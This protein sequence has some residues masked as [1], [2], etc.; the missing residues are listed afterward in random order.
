MTDRLRVL[1]LSDERGQLASQILNQLGADVIL[2]EPPGGSPVRRMA[3]FADDVPDPE[4]SLTFWGWNRGKRSVVVDGDTVR[5]RAELY[6]VWISHGVEIARFVLRG[7]EAAIQP[8]PPG[9]RLRRRGRGPPP[10]RS[11]DDG[12]GVPAEAIR[13]VIPRRRMLARR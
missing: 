3:P 8:H 5:G 6:A 10:V 2:V 13:H 4:G 7:D 12:G 1:D 9:T 11:V